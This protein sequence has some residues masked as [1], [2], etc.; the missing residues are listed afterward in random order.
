MT[1]TRD[2]GAAAEADDSAPAPARPG[3]VRA[4]WALPAAALAGLVA[5]LCGLVLPFA[6]VV[7]STP[8]VT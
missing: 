8:T 5:V 3:R 6:P 1:T 4:T 7:V 2:A